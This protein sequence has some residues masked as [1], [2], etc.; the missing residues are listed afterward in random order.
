MVRRQL[1]LSIPTLY[2][3]G[4]SQCWLR[5]VEQHHGPPGRFIQ[6]SCLCQRTRPASGPQQASPVSQHPFL[7]SGSM[8]PDAG[9]RAVLRLYHGASSPP[10]QQPEDLAGSACKSY[11]SLLHYG[12]RDT[13]SFNA[14]AAVQ[15]HFSCLVLP[16]KL[17]SARGACTRTFCLRSHLIAISIRIPVQAHM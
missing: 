1:S 14:A 11:S 5:G 12:A 16:E 6:T 9:G 17:Q 15:T 13:R 7:H 3:L 2:G 8:H 4:G 10:A